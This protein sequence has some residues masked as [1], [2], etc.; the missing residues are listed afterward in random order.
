MAFQTLLTKIQAQFETMCATG[1][2][3]I[4]SI[5]G[6]TL[7]QT[8]LSAFKP[9]NNPIWRVNSEHDGRNDHNFFR[10]YA[11]IV[12]IKNGKIISI[13]NLLLENCEYADSF[14]ACKELLANSAIEG[15][16]VQTYNELVT[17]PYEK[18]KPN[19]ANYRLGMEKNH[20]QYK[21]DDK[22]ELESEK[23]KGKEIGKVYTFYHYSV[24]IPKQFIDFSNKSKES[25]FGDLQTT[26]QLF[27]KGLLIPLESLELIRDLIQQGSMLRGDMYLQKVL[28]F[29]KI[30][31]EYELSTNKELFILENFWKTPFARFANELIG[32]T[33]IELAEGKELNKVVD[34]FNFRV[35]PVN[36]Q[37]AKNLEVSQ[38][39]KQEA[40]KKLKDLGYLTET[41]N[42]FNRRY[43]TIDDINV[44]EIRHTNV[45]NIVEKPL[46]LFGKV[47]TTGFSRHKRAEFDKVESVGIDKFMKDI[48][49]TVT[50]MEVFL[51]NKFNNNL[52]AL[53]T[54]AEECKNLMKWSN[55]FSWT[56]ENNLSGVSQIKE[57]VKS[58]GGKV[59]G[60]LRFSMM[61]ADGNDDDSDLDLHCV[62]PNNSYHIYYSNRGTPSPCGGKLDVDITSP[63]GKLAVE[64][65]IYPTLNRMKE[66]T[67]KLFIRQFSER[68]S[69]GFKA[70]VEFD[71]QL[72]SYTYNRR[73]D[74]DVQVAEV[75]L[76][77]GVFSI[78]HILPATEGEAAN[79]TIWNLETNQFHKVNLVCESPNHWGD[80]KIGTKEYF[81]M[82]QDCKSDKP[83]RTY[84]IDQLNPELLSERR[85][86]ELLGQYMTIEPAEKQLA[87]LGFNSTVKAELIV[88]LKGSHQR[89][90]KIQL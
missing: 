24:N 9:E 37:K 54:A 38:K 68:N 3:Y 86:L 29:I 30:R 28:D 67:Y 25:I 88:K 63:N 71:G 48:L 46:G 2:L 70:E 65:I 31:K 61:W 73:V 36:Y 1:K 21:A 75:T 8:Y 59:D 20:V 84:H 32:T 43:A 15:I 51:E 7:W 74:G 64:N 50:S 33:C 10:R 11:N 18:S 40:E 56:Y 44:S 22:T 41:S 55:P 83:M 81:F 17:L 52:V 79:R 80:N 45:D 6:E 39:A 49:P 66:G 62:E 42:S 26:K 89:V 87:G 14:L 35:D 23:A 5:D 58:K 85:A 16:F 19:Q 78:K 4:S 77:N 13:F 76:K 27:Q 82:L 69:K 34:S 47:P 90:I 57:E 60:V 72:Y 12:A 53:F